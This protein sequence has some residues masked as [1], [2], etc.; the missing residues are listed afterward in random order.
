MQCAPLLFSYFFHNTFLSY[1]SNSLKIVYIIIYSEKLLKHILFSILRYRWLRTCKTKDVFTLTA[2]L[3]DPWGEDRD[4]LRY[5]CQT[6]RVVFHHG[7]YATR[8]EGKGTVPS[9]TSGNCRIPRWLS[10][11]PPQPWVKR[12]DK[13]K[14]MHRIPVSQQ[15][16]NVILV[17]LWLG[18]FATFMK[19]LLNITKWLGFL[20][21]FMKRHINVFV[22]NVIW[23][24]ISYLY[25]LQEII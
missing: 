2:A 13:N 8:F 12:P 14:Y 9:A 25:T 11:A 24:N 5:L 19:R 21:T 15:T 22:Y 3:N 16:Q 20:A 7:V 10:W 1:F 18:Y 17:S 6:N 23:T 4:L